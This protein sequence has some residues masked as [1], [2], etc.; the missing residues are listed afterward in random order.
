MIYSDN[1]LLKKYLNYATYVV[2]IRTCIFYL[3]KSLFFFCNLHNYWF[4]NDDDDRVKISWRCLWRGNWANGSIVHATVEN[5]FNL[6][7]AAT[8]A[9]EEREREMIC[10]QQQLHSTFGEFGRASFSEDERV[11]RAACLIESSP[12][13]SSILPQPA[14]CIA[15]QGMEGSAFESTYIQATIFETKLLY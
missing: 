9:A 6:P 8:V 13:C 12:A 14:H 11:L 5:T 7:A 10:S 1:I 2:Y 3:I 4:Q 15:A